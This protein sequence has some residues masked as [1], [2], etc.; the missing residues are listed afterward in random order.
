MDKEA[1]ADD[2]SKGGKV[3]SAQPLSECKAAT[4]SKCRPPPPPIHAQPT[5][6]P[7]TPTFVPPST[8]TLVHPPTPT[9][10][11]LPTSTLAPL[12]LPTLASPPTSTLVPLASE[13]PSGNAPASASGPETPDDCLED[14]DV[15]DSAPAQ[16]GSIFTTGGGEPRQECVRPH[17]EGVDVVGAAGQIGRKVGGGARVQSWLEDARRQE[18]EACVSRGA[19]DTQKVNP[20][21]PTSKL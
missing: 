9:L 18:E 19:G 11:P 17:S 20:L 6:Q 5:L 10:V 2:A 14:F 1:A 8:S 21:T 12:P 13:S 7:D 3:C 15:W 16:L 4:S